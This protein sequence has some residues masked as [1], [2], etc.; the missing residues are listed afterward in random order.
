MFNVHSLNPKVSEES[1]STD[2]EFCKQCSFKEKGIDGH[3]ECLM[4]SIKDKW[5]S[6]SIVHYCDDPFAYK[7]IKLWNSRMVKNY[8]IKFM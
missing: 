1:F 8:K 3:D 6:P 4:E 2:S 5:Q 7:F